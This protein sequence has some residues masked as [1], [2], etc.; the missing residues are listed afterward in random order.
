MHVPAACAL[1][2]ALPESS[3]IGFSLA[4]VAVMLL[5][6]WW[7]DARARH[8][9]HAAPGLLRYGLV[10]LIALLLAGTLIAAYAW[11]TFTA[12]EAQT[13]HTVKQELTAV[14][15]AT[16]AALNNWAG[17]EL[18][19]LA[20]LAKGSAL[21]THTRSLLDKQEPSLLI[22]AS[23][24]SALRQYFRNNAAGEQADDYYLIAASGMNLFAP[25]EGE[26]ARQHTI[27][28]HRA[29]LLERVM[30]GEAVLVP[31]LPAQQG[32]SMLPQIAGFS[33]PATMFV[34]VPVREG[35]RV[36]AVLAKRLAPMGRFSEVLA[37]GHIGETGETY[38]VNSEGFMLSR[39]RFKEELVNLKLLM[40]N[41]ESVLS[42]K[43]VDPGPDQVTLR[44]YRVDEAITRA[45]WTAMMA[46]MRDKRGGVNVQG[47]RDY[48]G[49]PVV[50]AWLWNEYLG[51]GLATEIDFAEAM[52]PVVAY[53]QWLTDLLVLCA[54]ML[55]L[56]LFGVYK[57]ARFARLFE[58]R[59]REEHEAVL[60]H[61]QSS[62]EWETERLQAL[63]SAI[64]SPVY[65][66]DSDGELL[67][68]NVAAKEL[69]ALRLQET[70][71]NVSVVFKEMDQHILEQSLGKDGELGVVDT[72]GESR[73]FWFS[74]KLLTLVGTDLSERAHV[75]GF[76]VD[77]S[78]YHFDRN[79][80]QEQER[81]RLQER[82]TMQSLLDASNYAIIATD[83]DGT[84]KVFNK[85]AE[86]LLQY[87]ASELVGKHNPGVFH[88]PTEVGVRKQLLE[89]ELNRPIENDF[90]VFVAKAA[91]GFSDEQE[92][93]YIRKD[94]E[95][96]LV[97]LSVTA[98]RD[99]ANN[100]AGYLGIAS[101]ISERKQM[102]QA[103]V[104]AKEQ[105]E[106][107]NLAKSE[108]VASMSHEIRT[109]M[110][111]VLGMLGLVLQT[112]LD[113]NQKHKIEVAQQS[114]QSLLGIINDILDFSKVEAGKLELD[115]VPFQLHALFDE[116]A[117]S[118]A[119]RAEQKNL[120][121]FLDLTR[122]HVDFVE[123]D[124][125]RLRQILNNLLSNAI[126]FTAQGEIIVRVATR[127]YDEGHYQLMCAISDTGIGIP[128]DKQE[129]LFDSFTQVDASTTREYGGTGL[130][131]AICKKLVE[132]MQGSISVESEEGKGSTFRFNVLLRHY[133][134]GA[135][136][137]DVV[138]LR[139]RR[140]L[141]VDDHPVNLE[142]FEEQLTL[143]GAQVELV[144]SAEAA[145]SCCEKAQQNGQPFDV[146]LLDQN[147]PRCD[148]LDLAIQL[149]DLPDWP[150]TPLVM[151][152]SVSAQQSADTL[153]EHGLAAY[154]TK[155]VSPIDLRDVLSLVLG[156]SGASSTPTGE[157]LITDSTLVAPHSMTYADA[158]Q[159]GKSWP[160]ASRILLVEDNQV[161]QLVAQGM[162]KVLGLHCDLAGNGHEA[163]ESLRLAPDDAPY[164][165]IFMD[166]QMPE[167]DGYEATR[168]I[169]KGAAGDRYVHTPVIALTA[170]AMQGDKEKCMLAGMSDYLAK[171]LEDDALFD[172]LKHWLLGEQT[173]S[174]PSAVIKPEEK[175]SVTAEQPEQAESDAEQVSQ[176][177]GETPLWDEAAALS[178]LGNN[179]VL[180]RSVLQLYLDDARTRVV[181]MQTAVEAGRL[182][183]VGAHAHAL[184]G[185]SS[186]ISAQQA[187]EA[188][189][190]L[191]KAC[192]AG[193]SAQIP[194]C[195]AALTDSV[196]ALTRQLDE[197]VQQGDH[198]V[199]TEALTLADLP[200][201]LDNFAQRL[202]QGEFIDPDEMADL[203]QTAFGEPLDG[204]LQTLV[205][206][207]LCFDLEA[208]Q[209]SIA[210]IRDQISL[211]APS[212]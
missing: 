96:V 49:V 169:R 56:A 171:P 52:R 175:L 128:S 164:T 58:T 53:Q 190:A 205:Q 50:G 127:F 104:E 20:S 92:W 10:S 11:R 160:E 173:T 63:I 28:L 197:Y 110:N 151:L 66:R 146:I 31:P 99:G 36:I 174:A 184:K 69:F 68:A 153:K 16:N 187:R 91:L 51:I 203:K 155:P 81:L 168:E 179:A 102:E 80:R 141:V 136:K 130:G 183:E 5:G 101:D 202:K 103:L 144:A 89:Q 90:E 154:L 38:A 122:V 182:E 209:S 54:L 41:E 152:T 97:S 189:Q 73:T 207:L 132:L 39:S 135:R 87:S 210:A 212:P 177:Q 29:D 181:A 125:G 131:L 191:E 47:Y 86:Q 43:I 163:L 120:G 117:K 83:T 199:G 145:L 178:R 8:F 9:E 204:L 192:R 25:L 109:P 147:M 45:P 119:V 107:A 98:L 185:A 170:N 23:E 148:G 18:A 32:E 22:Y 161:N 124:P 167:M 27:V 71:A 62:L 108:F 35:N 93:T 143:W 176:A 2:Q 57:I 24:Q 3:F 116:S 126:K 55:V 123:G 84:I 194:V 59:L 200:A 142:I 201:R 64:P 85:A 4:V 60:V 30:R 72:S 157:A 162:M 198:H 40:P 114:A 137:L 100:I 186:N 159:L 196:E 118:L 106:I 95:H 70:G 7:A 158:H 19:Q 134:G 61:Q 105:A 78:R 139:E 79:Q 13:K 129:H 42:V 113:A 180:L 34:A 14:L 37:Q 112:D 48:R 77:V 82:Q 76:A 21:Q 206:Q 149:Q 67:V 195:F 150:H 133:E 17:G 46:A 188:A 172:M 26:I 1:P 165:L 94:G 208:A 115:H 140:L 211:R 121:F 74:K 111:G 75:L 44:H 88:D 166:C 12:L 6:C 33:V 15:N 193:E 156:E 138:D 65:L